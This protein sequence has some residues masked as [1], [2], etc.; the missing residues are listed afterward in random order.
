M[1]NVSP[2]KE[3]SPGIVTRIWW[4][5]LQ[6][7]HVFFRRL[8]SHTGL[9][10]ITQCAVC[11]R[12]TRRYPFLCLRAT[13][14]VAMTITKQYFVAGVARIFTV[15]ELTCLLPVKYCCTG[16]LDSIPSRVI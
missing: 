2:K 9:A 5:P 11:K 12:R 16:V 13:L 10:E 6:A 3:K 1:T 8:V 4:V 14:Y 7:R 15:Q